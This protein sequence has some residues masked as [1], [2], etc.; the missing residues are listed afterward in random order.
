MRA[1]FR[2]LEDRLEL[3]QVLDVFLAGG[4]AVHLYT[5]DRKTTDVDAEFSAR[6]HV[7]NALAVEV[8][9]KD[10]LPMVLYLDTNYNSTFALMH[11]DYR[12]D[13]LPVD[14]G[15]D[16]IRVHVL[17]PVD[18]AVS[19]IARLAGNDKKDI[20]AL[21]RLGLTTADEIKQRAVEALAG[22]AGSRS[23][24]RLNIQETVRELRELENGEESDDDHNFTH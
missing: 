5:G 9:Q 16:W 6:L 7:S 23:T 1:L 21:V 4:M 10:S 19:K 24:L 20:A 12:E 17:A 14:M 8:E 18:L 3:N 11:E 22:Y 13:S 2:Q 15:L